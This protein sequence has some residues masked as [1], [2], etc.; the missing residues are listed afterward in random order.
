VSFSCCQE[1]NKDIVRRLNLSVC[2]ISKVTD[3]ILKFNAAGLHSSTKF[4]FGFYQSNRTLPLCGAHQTVR[5]LE[6]QI[7]IHLRSTAF[8]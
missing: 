7:I 4:N 6:K 8:I 2:S 1:Q 3:Q 5:F